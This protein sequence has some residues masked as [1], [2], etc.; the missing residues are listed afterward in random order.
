MI[1][2]LDFLS[3]FHNCCSPRTSQNTWKHLKK[4]CSSY[5]LGDGCLVE[6]VSKIPQKRPPKPHL[7]AYF[8]PCR[9][10]KGSLGTS[11]FRLFRRSIFGHILVALWLTFGSPFDSLWGPF[12]S[13]WPPFGSLCVPFRSILTPFGYIVAPFCS[14]FVS[15]DAFS[16][17]F[18]PYLSEK[19]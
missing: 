19:T 7:W 9:V 5:A 2:R 6:N 8:C 11:F 12:G 15:L 3:K 13:R 10:F 18:A 14:R 4:Q 16:L 1:F 17:H